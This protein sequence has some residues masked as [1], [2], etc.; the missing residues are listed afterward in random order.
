MRLSE[1]RKKAPLA[2]AASDDVMA[3]I[4][5]I[6]VD[7]GARADAD[8]WVIWGEDPGMKYSILAPALA[9]LISI[10]VRPLGSIE[11]P[12]ATGKLTRW[13][14]LNV[15]ELGVEA[16]GGHRIVAVQVE[17]YVLKGVDDEADR[18]CEFVRGI[19]AGV[20]N[21]I[22]QQ[23]IAPMAVGSLAVGAPRVVSGVAVGGAPVPRRVATVS[24]AKEPAAGK[25][26]P[27][28][29]PANAPTGRP[30]RAK[31]G[32]RVAREVTA[33]PIAVEA[34]RTQP[35]ESASPVPAAAV[36]AVP[37]AAAAVGA[38]TAVV[39]AATA[40]SAAQAPADTAGTSAGPKPIS[41]R[42][43][44]HQE[45]EPDAPPA[46]RGDWVSPHTIAV[47]HSRPKAKPRRWTP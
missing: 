39:G 10:A 18:I 5:P 3:I 25:A 14:K 12:R 17:S 38:A 45:I 20:E 46:A 2:E 35:A 11:G 34:A 32:P 9:G 24:G 37:E 16:A 30:S 6:L 27:K 33:A 31:G 13:S 41:S 23:V 4:E 29:V 8:C 43:A 28:T 42:S 15:T 22:P 36:A 26:A 19:V 7:L 21:R 1:W 47:P 40:G 44:A